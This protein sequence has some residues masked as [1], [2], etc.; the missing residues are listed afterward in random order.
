[1]LLP[2]DYFLPSAEINGNYAANGFEALAGE[3]P[4][5]TPFDTLTLCSSQSY[6]FLLGAKGRYRSAFSYNLWGGYSILRDACFFYNTADARGNYFDLWYDNGSRVSFNGQFT[7]NFT[8][9]FGLQML[10]GFEKYTLDSLAHP[11][12]RPEHRLS[13]QARYNLWNKLTLSAGVDFRGSYYA[14]SVLHPFTPD[15]KL[16]YLQ[17]PAGCDLSINA[18]Y[19]FF[20][21]ASA[22]IRLNNLLNSS[23]QTYSGYDNYGIGIFIGGALTF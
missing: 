4:Y 20:N 5:I 19:R 15:G 7:F 2:D 1:V 21:K 13:A 8:R 3:N 6:D 12:H 22:F 10:Y 16:Q 23:Y 11:L 14:F 17:R 18:E 9:A